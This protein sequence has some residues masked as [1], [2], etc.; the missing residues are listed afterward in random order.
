MRKA[1]A[2]RP[3][4]PLIDPGAPAVCEGCTEC[5]D[6]RDLGLY[7]RLGP[8]TWMCKRCWDRND[9]PSPMRTDPALVHQREEE[10]RKRMLSRGGA[11][12]HLVRKGLT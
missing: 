9:Q 4:P 7:V 3:Q 2:T 12:R 11:F 5:G 10:T 1:P 6:C 8:K